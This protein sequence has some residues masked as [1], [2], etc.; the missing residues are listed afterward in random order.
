M[1]SDKAPFPSAPVDDESSSTGAYRQPAEAP[2]PPQP[3]VVNTIH[4]GAPVQT[5]LSEAPPPY[6]AALRSPVNPPYPLGEAKGQPS[7]YSAPPYQP[8]Q[9][10][11]NP[12]PESSATV[13]EIRYRGDCPHCQ[14]GDV[15]KET[16]VCCLT[17][18]LIIALFTL[19][20]GLFFLCCIPCTWKKRC[21][22]CRKTV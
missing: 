17:C 2:Q 7:A 14:T 20:L 3:E 12:I 13:V 1:P 15:R 21:S 16:D 18:L 22:H 11:P 8:Q 9:I 5:P 6:E 19:P 4:V 10:N